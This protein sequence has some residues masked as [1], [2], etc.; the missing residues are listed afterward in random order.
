MQACAGVPAP[1]GWMTVAPR[2]RALRHLLPLMKLRCIIFSTTL[3][4]S[5]IVHSQSLLNP[6][7]PP[8]GAA[9][10]GL[11][12]QR[13]AKWELQKRTRCHM[14]ALP[15]FHLCLSN[16]CVPV[17]GTKMGLCGAQRFESPKAARQIRSLRSEMARVARLP[18]SSFKL[19]FSLNPVNLDWTCRFP[20]SCFTPVVS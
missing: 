20:V 19:P 8:G 16:D 15:C 13:L 1:R 5:D 17:F 4:S 18:S 7:R 2:V 9:R 11:W 10:P 3:Q 14:L 6:R 12:L